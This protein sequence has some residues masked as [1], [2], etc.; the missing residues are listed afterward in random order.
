MPT[1]VCSG[2]VRSGRTAMGWLGATRGGGAGAGRPGL[3]A[4]ASAAL[5]SGLPAVPGVDGVS[6]DRRWMGMGS[7]IT[8]RPAGLP[9]PAALLTSGRAATGGLLAGRGRGAGAGLPPELAGIAAA[10][11]IAVAVAVAGIA[12]GFG[13]AGDAEAFMGKACAGTGSDACS[14]PKVLGGPGSGC[15]PVLPRGRGGYWRTES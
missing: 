12:A 15:R 13:D 5:A 4:G 10:S 9:A 14:G 6:E 11:G 7:L 8:G 3:R 2:R 1:A